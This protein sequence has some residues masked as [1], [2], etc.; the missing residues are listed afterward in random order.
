MNCEHAQ[1]WMMMISDDLSEARRD[2]P[3]RT[4]EPAA[5]LRARITEDEAILGWLQRSGHAVGGSSDAPA[6]G[7]SIGEPAQAV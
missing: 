3:G 1:R 4:G 6:V 2:L 7:Y 5:Y